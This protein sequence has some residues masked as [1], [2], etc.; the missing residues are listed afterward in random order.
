VATLNGAFVQAM[1]ASAVRDKMRNL[2]L[3]VRE[4]SAAEFAAV[5]KT[6]YGR[7][8]PIIRASGFSGDN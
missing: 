4:M 7:W 5:V 6:D 2:D 1:R 3:E 8:G